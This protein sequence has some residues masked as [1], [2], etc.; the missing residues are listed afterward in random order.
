MMHIGSP[1][2]NLIYGDHDGDGPSEADTN[3]FLN[4]DD[5]NH[6]I[7]VTSTVPSLSAESDKEERVVVGTLVVEI[8]R[9]K[10][11]QVALPLLRTS[12]PFVVLD[13]ENQHHKTKVVNSEKVPSGKWMRFQGLNPVFS[14]EKFVFNVTD[15]TETLRLK[16]MSARPM[17][18]DVVLGHICIPLVDLHPGRSSV[19]SAMLK[20]YAGIITG[21]APSPVSRKAWHEIL[22]IHKQPEAP[23]PNGGDFHFQSGVQGVPNTATGNMP[24]E[25]RGCLEVRATLKLH[26][27]LI[28]CYMKNPR[29]RPFSQLPNKLSTAAI[30][31]SQRR[32]KRTIQSKFRVNIVMQ[33]LFAWD[34][35]FLSA[36]YFCFSVYVS[37]FCPV[38]QLPIFFAL[39]FGLLCLSAHTHVDHVQSE[40]ILF[41]DDIIKDPELPD[42]VGKKLRL[43]ARLGLGLQKVLWVLASF[44]ERGANAFSFQDI[45]VTNIIVGCVFCS[46]CIFSF[47]LYVLAMFVE[48]LG[49]HFVFITVPRMFITLLI[50]FRFLYYPIKCL[51]KQKGI[52]CKPQSDTKLKAP[53]R[54]HAIK[55][56]LCNILQR[57]PDGYEMNH[58]RIASKQIRATESGEPEVVWCK[59]KK[60]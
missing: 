58:R 20:Q 12:Q 40:I 19:T 24:S 37:M 32:L 45:A 26:M 44:I 8:L 5:L 1:Y 41:N 56:A 46:M 38:W 25:A 60:E 57:V 39:I 36:T 10:N 33:R 6:A 13:F 42:T 35:V 30:Q 50:V 31:C 2:R 17:R 55:R 4:G 11:L 21:S 15:V 9:A 47:M 27:P 7:A 51:V 18:E 53:K 48:V 59:K 52:E 29:T 22:K 28:R 49:P 14:H 43:L 16:V 54:L 3:K 23:D 34:S